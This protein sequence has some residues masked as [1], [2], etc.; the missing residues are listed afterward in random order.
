MTWDDAFLILS[1][2][3]LVAGSLLSLV[4]AIGMVRFPELLTRM[5]AATKPQVLG[6]M[7]VLVGI[8]ASLRS[9]SA[10][11]LLALVALFQ[12]ATAP[13][14]AHMV[15]RASFRAGQ[16]RQEL[17]IIDE[18][19]PVIEAEQASSD[20]ADDEHDPELDDPS[21]PPFHSDHLPQRG[22]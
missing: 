1:G 8:A 22:D 6:L 2:L 15:S 10:M 9:A 5:H 13:I 4:A 17:L 20:P 11:G 21:D 12:L 3:C 16:V 18:L 14:S 7:L 19:T